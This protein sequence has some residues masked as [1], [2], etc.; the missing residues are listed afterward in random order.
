[1][2]R[3]FFYNTETGA[4][5]HSHYEVRVIDDPDNGDVRLSAPAAVDL[6]EGMAELV[7]RGLDPHRIRGLATTVMPESSRRTQRSVDLQTGKLRSRRLDLADD[8]IG[9]EN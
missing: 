8:V 5:L 3:T 9:E 2:N 1:M 7:S 6:D 4:L